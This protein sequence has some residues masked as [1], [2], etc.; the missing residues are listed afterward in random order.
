LRAPGLGATASL[1]RRTT[2]GWKTF[3]TLR[4]QANG[5]VTWHGTLPRGSRV[6]LEAGSTAGAEIVV[7]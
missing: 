6:R 2:T 4:A 5:Y 1:E 7:R 3:A